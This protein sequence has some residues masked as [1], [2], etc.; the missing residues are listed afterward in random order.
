MKT[1]G[2]CRIKVALAITFCLT[3]LLL[4]GTSALAGSLTFKEVTS[5]LDLQK[6]TSLHVKS[7]WNKVRGET[8]TWSAKVHDV[9]GGRGKAQVF[10]V[11]PSGRKYKGFNLVLITFDMDAA[12]DLQI[13]DKIKFT[14]ELYKYKGHRGSP[15]I[16]YLNNVEFLK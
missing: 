16:L 11:E 10:A 2:V 15:V 6:K 3:F 12:A 9:K 4:A 7:Y 8:V 5:Q 1:C 13:N 14:G